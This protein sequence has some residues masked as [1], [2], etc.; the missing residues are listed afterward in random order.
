MTTKQDAIKIIGLYFLVMLST[1]LVQLLVVPLL[2][3]QLED[4]AFAITF[5]T[6]LNFLIYAVITVLFILVFK[7]LFQF[8]FKMVKQNISETMK[9]SLIGF[10]VMMVFVVLIGVI[11][12][13][14]DITETSVNQAALDFMFEQ[15]R[16]IDWV[17][18]A[19][20]TILLAPIVEEF[21]FRKAVMAFFKKVPAVAIII[22]GIAFGYIHVASDD[23]RQ[24]IYYML[25]GMVLA[26]FYV[27]SKY[28][29]F[30]PIIMHM[31]FN[32]FLVSLMII[33]YSML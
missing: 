26:G 10:G 1:L 32:G 2:E 19:I 5:N 28:N 33:Q 16:I 4:E 15:G 14:L 23:Y 6:G 25:I 12:Q 20:F 17:F 7:H 21:V 22:S 18:L 30:V 3:T 9:Y 24:I 8:D 31:I 13:Y 29:I 27:L 11:Y